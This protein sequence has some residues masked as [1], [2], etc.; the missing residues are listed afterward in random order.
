MKIH[1]FTGKPPKKRALPKCRP[2]PSTCSAVFHNEVE[3]PG[4]SFAEK[5]VSE[6]LEDALASR[7]PPPAAVSLNLD[8]AGSVVSS[9]VGK[10]PKV[11]SGEPLFGWLDP[12]SEPRVSASIGEGHSRD[13]LMGELV[14]CSVGCAG[15]PT[16]EVGQTSNF[17]LL[18]ELDPDALFPQQQ[19]SY[20]EIYQGATGRLPIP[21]A[22]ATESARPPPFVF[23]GLSVLE[24]SCGD[25]KSNFC[26]Q[27]QL[28]FLDLVKTIAPYALAHIDRASLPGDRKLK[29]LSPLARRVAAQI[30][31][32][33]RAPDKSVHKDEALHDI[34]SFPATILSPRPLEPLSFVSGKGEV[35]LM[36]EA[37]QGLGSSPPVKFSPRI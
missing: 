21:F 22:D 6:D 25:P 32:L 16:I 14:H 35:V 3:C 5:A 7:P 29:D 31:T 30:N 19:G 37:L 10:H 20:Q 18:N 28:V 17:D 34:A 23:P 15:I 2:M 24:P 11:V 36:D 13:I 8:D 27:H 4:N 1:S 9:H 33:L 12:S 26:E